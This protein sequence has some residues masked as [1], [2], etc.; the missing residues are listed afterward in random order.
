MATGLNEL[1][2]LRQFQPPERSDR[3]RSVACAPFATEHHRFAAL[4][5]IACRIAANAPASCY[6]EGVVKPEQASPLDQ[7]GTG[8]NPPGCRALRRPRASRAAR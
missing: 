5:F 2:H 8:E 3:T 1:R 4:R 6:L 7:P